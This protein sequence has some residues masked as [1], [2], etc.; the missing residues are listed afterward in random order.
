[1]KTQASQVMPK[2]RQKSARLSKKDRKLDKL[3]RQQRRIK[4]GKHFSYTD[5]SN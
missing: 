3:A 1:M 4:P 5:T 2:Y